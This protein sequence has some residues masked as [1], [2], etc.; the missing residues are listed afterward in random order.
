MLP[1]GAFLKIIDNSGARLGQIIWTRFGTAGAGN[2]VKVAIKEA[3][4]GKVTKGQMKKAVVVE[5]KYPTRR[6]NV[7]RMRW[8]ADRLN[9]WL[10]AIQMCTIILQY[11][12]ALV[13][14]VSGCCIGPN[15]W[16]IDRIQQTAAYTVAATAAQQLSQKL[17]V[18]PRDQALMVV[19]IGCA[20]S[21]T[22]LTLVLVLQH[23]VQPGQM[24]WPVLLLRQAVM[25]G[26]L[27]LMFT[28]KHQES[29]RRKAIYKH[30]AARAVLQR[31]NEWWTGVFHGNV[32]EIDRCGHGFVHHRNEMENDDWGNSHLDR[33]SLFHFCQ[34]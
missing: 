30:P 28:A 13:P 12:I 31:V 27:V 24:H 34:L 22:G 10:A 17:L 11:V 8:F 9:F 2:V 3:K 23:L 4:G 5:T 15:N 29:H 7:S 21:T 18:D 14:V 20:I 16:C 32:P 1:K 6:P 25:T 26:A 33:A 19:S